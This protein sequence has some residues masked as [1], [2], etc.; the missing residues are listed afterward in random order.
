[1]TL[2]RD[3]PFGM[4]AVVAPIIR[5]VLGESLRN[6][7]EHTRQAVLNEPHLIN[8]RGF[9]IGPN[10]SHGPITRNL[11]VK[12]P[13]FIQS[14]IRMAAGFRCPENSSRRFRGVNSSISVLLAGP[15][16]RRKRYRIRCTELTRMATGLSI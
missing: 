7:L 1:V 3:V 4:G 11:Q 6:S 10:K 16:W 13:R 2:T 15:V 14:G 12:G 8:R 9:D 5:N